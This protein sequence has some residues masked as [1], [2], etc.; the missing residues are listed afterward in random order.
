MKKIWRL[1]PQPKRRQRGGG[2]KEDED[3][4]GRKHGKEGRQR[5]SSI[6]RT[7]NTG[8]FRFQNKMD[9]F[10]D[11]SWKWLTPYSQIM[12]PQ[13]LRML[14]VSMATRMHKSYKSLVLDPS[15]NS[16]Q[17]KHTKSISKNFKKKENTPMTCLLVFRA[18]IQVGD[19]HIILAAAIL[20]PWID[21]LDLRNWP[22]KRTPKN[23]MPAELRGFQIQ[24][25]AG[26]AFV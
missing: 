23:N 13:H 17:K 15:T 10:A 18:K 19:G 2:Q 20:M 1:K 8:S 7:R 9:F 14:K 12:D 24:K 26:W 22:K 3:E 16:W 25:L 11:K 21:F 4:D 6:R 5:K